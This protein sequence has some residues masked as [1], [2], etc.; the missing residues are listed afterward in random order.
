MTSHVIIRLTADQRVS[1][2]HLSHRATQPIAPGGRAGVVCRTVGPKWA[3]HHV[4]TVGEGS[5]TT[6]HQIQQLGANQRVGGADLSHCAAEPIAPS[7]RAGIACRAVGPVSAPHHVI[8]VG[9]GGDT[10]SQLIPRLGAD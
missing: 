4:I 6:S 5:D 10:T 7:R 1:G 9:E 3:P 8:A 2:A